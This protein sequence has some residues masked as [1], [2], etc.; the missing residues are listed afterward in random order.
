MWVFGRIA[1]FIEGIISVKVLGYFICWR[2]RG[3]SRVSLE[4]F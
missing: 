3:W 1:F 2:K 4:D